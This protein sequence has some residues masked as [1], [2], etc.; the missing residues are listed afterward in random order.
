MVIK[1]GQGSKKQKEELLKDP[2]GCGVGGGIGT[3]KFFVG[4]SLSMA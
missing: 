2:S 3:T 4:G 1:R